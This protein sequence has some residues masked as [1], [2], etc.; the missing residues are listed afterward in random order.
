MGLVRDTKVLVDEREP[1]L[2]EL[3]GAVDTLRLWG[4]P[5]SSGSM[6]EENLT[7]CGGA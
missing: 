5:V 7:G 6:Q 1:E 3:D 4:P 2:L